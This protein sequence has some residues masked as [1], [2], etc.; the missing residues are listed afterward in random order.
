M[1]DLESVE[2]AVR[3]TRSRIRDGGPLTTLLDVLADEILRIILEK[4]HEAGE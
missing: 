1:T 3:R 2:M 4:D